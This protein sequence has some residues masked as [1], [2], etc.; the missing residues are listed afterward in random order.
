MAALQVHLSSPNEKDPTAYLWLQRNDHQRRKRPLSQ[1]S[2]ISQ[3]IPG[4]WPKAV[5]LVLLLRGQMLRRTRRNKSRR[6]GGVRE[7]ASRG[8]VKGIWGKG[9][10]VRGRCDLHRYTASRTWEPLYLY[11]SEQMT[12]GG[13]IPLAPQ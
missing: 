9:I 13:S 8:E 1:R 5:S 11:V 3:G 4:L 12:V 7:P 6:K 10:A 2:T